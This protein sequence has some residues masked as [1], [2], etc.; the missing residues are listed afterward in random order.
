M[1]INKQDWNKSKPAKQKIGYDSTIFNKT[2]NDEANPIAN[3]F[4]ENNFDQIS[5]NTNPF[6]KSNP[7][8]ENPLKSKL[9]LINPTKP[10]SNLNLTVNSNVNQYSNNQL[11]NSALISNPKSVLKLE[12]YK[13]GT[14]AILDQPKVLKFVPAEITEDYRMFKVDEHSLKS[15]VLISKDLGECANGINLVYDI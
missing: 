14:I 6:K 11:N 15:K 1:L 12:S 10:H 8:D 5:L 9:S 7:I 13:F 4:V 3:D 2:N